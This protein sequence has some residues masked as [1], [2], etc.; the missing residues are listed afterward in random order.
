MSHESRD[1][2]K[3]HESDDARSNHSADQDNQ[4]DSQARRLRHDQDQEQSQDESQDSERRAP[5]TDGRRHEHEHRKDHHHSD[6][7]SRREHEHHSHREAS[8]DAEE[9]TP[10]RNASDR[11]AAGPPH[12]HHAHDRPHHR[13]ATM[14]ATSRTAT[15]APTRRSSHPMTMTR[16][17]R[18]A[19]MPRI[20]GSREPSGRIARSRPIG[21]MATSVPARPAKR[22][23]AR[24]RSPANGRAALDASGCRAV[25]GRRPRRRL[26][27]PSPAYSGAPAPLRAASRRLDR[28]ID[29]PGSGDRRDRGPDVQSLHAQGPGPV[30]PEGPQR[31]RRPLDG[32]P[33]TISRTPRPWRNSGPARPSRPPTRPR[34]TSVWPRP[35]QQAYLATQ[36]QLRRRRTAQ[37]Q[38]QAENQQRLY[39]TQI[40]LA[41]QAWDRGDTNEVLRLLEPYRSDPARQKL[42]SF[43]WYY[44]WR[45]AHNGGS[46]TLRGHADVVRQAVVTPDGSA[47]HHLRRRRP[48]DR[49]GCGRGPQVGGH[50]P[51]AERAAADA[52]PD[53]AKTSWPV[54]PA[55]WSSPATAQWAAAYGR[56]LYVGSNIRQPDAVRPVTDHQ[57]PIISLAIEP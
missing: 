16:N 36:E 41:K 26:P 6:V 27:E 37:Q 13:A 10:H 29:G 35:N 11:P 4:N 32:G 2:N 56:N 47:N 25:S 12:S 39:V 30:G 49:L 28:T 22:R 1:G 50:G 46:N 17:R 43:A 31:V 5:S 33:T 7:E 55:G 45:A 19:T 20:R 52:R 24:A 44:L 3:P 53:R 14:K 23:W 54:M 57:S 51:G 8:D 48:V 34:R 42:C 38:T 9:E 40:R 21:L 15:T 18:A